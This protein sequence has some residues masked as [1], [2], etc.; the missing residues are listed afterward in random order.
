MGGNT[1]LP[2]FEHGSVLIT[3]QNNHFMAGQTIS[4][5]VSYLC[6]K[7]YPAEKLQ[8]ELTGYERLMWEGSDDKSRSAKHSDMIYVKTNTLRIT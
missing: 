5:Q 4:G 6:D 8:L 2:K 7:P 1:S 3:L